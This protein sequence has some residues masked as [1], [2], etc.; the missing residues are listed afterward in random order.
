[1][2]FMGKSMVSG[3]DFPLNQSVEI[4]NI[5]LVILVTL[6]FEI[7]SVNPGKREATGLWNIGPF[8]AIN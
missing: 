1:M 6:F 3:E 2:I 7:G 4:C 5:F 8:G